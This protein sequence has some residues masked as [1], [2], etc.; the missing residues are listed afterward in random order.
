MAGKKSCSVFFKPF[1]VPFRSVF[2]YLILWTGSTS[3]LTWSVKAVKIL[4]N[5]K[6]VIKSN[7][8]LSK[9]F[10]L[11]FITAS[12]V[13]TLMKQDVLV[14]NFLTPLSRPEHKNQTEQ[15]TVTQEKATSPFKAIFFST[16]GKLRTVKALPTW[17]GLQFFYEYTGNSTNILMAS[18]FQLLH[19][20]WGTQGREVPVLAG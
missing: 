15:R 1:W 16:E 6:P 17:W 8:I 13:C 2:H 11:C 4:S 19:A 7:A 18:S 3:V 20:L 10:Y 12:P 9:V 14:F 5:R